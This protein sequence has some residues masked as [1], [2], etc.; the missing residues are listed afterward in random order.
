[1][2][3]EAE[4]FKKYE[5]L[6]NQRASFYAKKW[7]VEFEE[8]QG[9]ALELYCKALQS[10]DSDKAA[11]ST[12]LYSKLQQLNNYCKLQAYHGNTTNI[13]TVPA[14]AISV[15]ETHDCILHNSIKTELSTIAQEVV[16]SI[17]DGTGL[18]IEPFKMIFSIAWMTEKYKLDFY[19]AQ[20]IHNEI[21]TWWNRFYSEI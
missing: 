21:H 4:H 9:R 14:E 16:E 10:Y 17:L 11:F 18:C 5:K 20:N 19:T 6:I 2:R 12:Y 13:E 3:K 8:V 1:M 15:T 7:N